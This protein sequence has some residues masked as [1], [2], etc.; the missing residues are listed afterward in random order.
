LRRNKSGD[1]Y[2]VRRTGYV[3]KTD[4]LAQADRY[5]VAAMLAANA[6]LQPRTGR[7]SALGD[8][9]HEYRWSK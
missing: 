3:I 8:E 5:R 9:A 6:K 4:R 7:P 1:R 2:S